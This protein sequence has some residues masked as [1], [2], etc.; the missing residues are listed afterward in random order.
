MLAGLDAVG[1]IR[2]DSWRIDEDR[3]PERSQPRDHGRALGF[4]ATSAQAIPRTSAGYFLEVID[5]LRATL[6]ALQ[7]KVDAVPDSIETPAGAQEK[8]T[9][10]QQAA[11][12]Y[13]DNALDDVVFAAA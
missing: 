2:Y 8:A 12:S 10:A 4:T 1:Q 13:V 9:A 3:R 7:T 5:E 11:I 6:T